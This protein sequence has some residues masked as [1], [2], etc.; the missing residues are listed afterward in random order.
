MKLL[1]VLFIS[2]FLMS[3]TRSL[4][5]KTGL[6]LVIP[7]SSKLQA[8]QTTMMPTFASVNVHYSDRPTISRS[9]ELKDRYGADNT[10]GPITTSDLEIFVPSV[11]QGT[12]TLIQL[13][14]VYEDPN[15]GVMEF[16]YGDVI[17]NITGGENFLDI[18]V[19]PI[20]TSTQ[21]TIFAGRYLE[22]ANQGPT[23]IV[24]MML[25]PP[26]GKPAMEVEKEPINNG[27]FRFFHPGGGAQFSYVL[28]GQK[29]VLFDKITETSS[30]FTTSNHLLKV[31]M[32][33]HQSKD[34]YGYY[35]SEVATNLYFGFY[36]SPESSID[37]ASYKACYSNRAHAIP[38]AYTQTSPNFSPLIMGTDVVVSGGVSLGFEQIYNSTNCD[39]SSGTNVVLHT[40]HLGDHGIDGNALGQMG[41][42]AMLNPFQKHDS[43]FVKSSSN[44]SSI[45]INWAYLPGVLGNSITGTTVFA[46]Y[47][48]Y[49]DGGYG[50]DDFN[51]R[52]RAE[53]EGMIAVEDT[54]SSSYSFTGGAGLPSPTDTNVNIRDFKFMLCPFKQTATG[55]RLYSREGISVHCI[56]GC[57]DPFDFGLGHLDA[58]D[59]TAAT[60]YTDL[61]GSFGAKVS[62]YTVNTTD[63]TMVLT[64]ESPW[65]ANTLVAGDEVVLNVVAAGDD[66]QCGTG[67]GSENIGPGFFIF[68]KVLSGSAS[69]AV[70]PRNSKIESIPVAELG[71]APSATVNYCFLNLIKVLEFRNLTISSELSTVPASLTT[72]SVQNIFLKLT[73]TLTLAGGTINAN[74]KG[75]SGGSFQKRGAG[76][77]GPENANTQTR[78][79]GA[80]LGSSFG[81]GGAGYGD[82]GESDNGQMAYGIYHEGMY[83]GGGGAG[84]PSIGGKTG[85][86]LIY[87]TARNVDLQTADSF[88]KADGLSTTGAGE[89]AGAGGNI[90]FLFD[91]VINSGSSIY[92]SAKGGSTPDSAGAG[93]GGF[94]NGKV[95]NGD[96]SYF[97][98]DNSGGA[99][100]AGANQS[101]KAGNFVD[102]FNSQYDWACEN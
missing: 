9:F 94:I 30:I 90:W 19:T 97:I 78:T 11:A 32:P 66:G 47:D 18:T 28:K 29:K 89:G 33:A 25:H 102:L 93:G 59:I 76:I 26:N 77:L 24:S 5:D 95:C 74:G 14:V 88:I 73:G 56:G 42:F 2:V 84:G 62:N 52:E 63:D 91:E 71:T 16:N 20:G 10:T 82:G 96:S 4:D 35:R 65:N 12:N 80:I 1:I 21:E 7:A 39:I 68:T 61:P 67:S 23:G 48:S 15:G 49:G 41:P 45:D 83:M 70:I 55:E 72:P 99:S 6:K 75:F 38:G 54:N 85:G 27:W 43:A 31:D 36:Q 46:K 13:L 57:N 69:M 64:L 58:P 37:L 40:E 86:G 44:S 22:A 50:Y 60:L 3:C 98:P 79:G 34:G 81:G 101:G 87:I 17:S 8:Q 100:S 51:C 53:L 92:I